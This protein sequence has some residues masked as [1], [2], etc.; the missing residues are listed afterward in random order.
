MKYLNMIVRIR[1]CFGR[2]WMFRALKFN[3]TEPKWSRIL[4]VS[5]H[6]FI[7]G[8]LNFSYYVF[9][10]GM[11]FGYKTDYTSFL[12]TWNKRQLRSV[13]EY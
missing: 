5:P 2:H 6:D 1:T 12:T 4:D 10:N 11:C 8:F 3:S 7:L 9:Y 13:T